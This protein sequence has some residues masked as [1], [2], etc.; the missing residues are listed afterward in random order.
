MVMAMMMATAEYACSSVAATRSSA[1]SATARIGL[2]RLPNERFDQDAAVSLHHRQLPPGLA[3]ITAGSEDASC[4]IPLGA[5]RPMTRAEPQSEAL[6]ERSEDV[7]V[8]AEFFGIRP[9]LHPSIV[10]LPGVTLHG[11]CFRALE[12]DDDEAPIRRFDAQN[13]DAATRQEPPLLV[14]KPREDGTRYLR[15]LLDL[16]GPRRELGQP[17]V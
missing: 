4:S 6:E 1:S 9:R 12:L 5:S 13:V 11:L 17:T 16:F 8:P 7:G 3:T 2:T 15:I 14:N 10:A